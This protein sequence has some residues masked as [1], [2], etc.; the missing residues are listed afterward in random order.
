MRASSRHVRISRRTRSVR[1]ALVALV[2]ALVVGLAGPVAVAVAESRHG[3]DAVV[4]EVRVP[5][6]TTAGSDLRV[7]VRAVDARGRVVRDYRGTVALTSTSASDGLPATYAFTTRDR[8]THTF[9]RVELR[10]AGPGTVTAADVARP[11]VTGTS[12]DVVVRPGRAREL[13]VTTPATTAAGTRADV[14]VTAQDRW[15]N[16][17]SSYTG[18]VALRSTDT[19]DG[20]V[21]EPRRH[22]FTRAD[23]GTVTFTDPVGVVLVTEGVQTVSAA[24]VR[25]RWLAGSATVTVTPV[26]VPTGGL[27]AQG[28]GMDLFGGLGDGGEDEYAT[29]DLR[30]VVGGAVWTDV[31]AGEFSS[32]GVREDGTLWAWGSI[33]RDGEYLDQGEPLR[34]GD[35][36]DWASVAGE[37]ALKRDGTLW[38]WEPTE[39]GGPPLGVPVQVGT[40]A[41]WADVADG[42][43]HVVALKT[44]GTLWSWGDTNHWGQQGNG[45]GEP[46]PA[47]RQVGTDADWASISAHVYQSVAI[48]TDGTLWGWGLDPADA[49]RPDAEP[50]VRTVPEQVGTDSDWAVV[51]AGYLHT[52]ALKRDGTLWSWGDNA[53]GALG[54]GTTTSSAVPVPES[55]GATWTAVAAGDGLTAAVATDGTL[56]RWGNGEL[57]APSPE[58]PFPDPAQVGTDTGW[59]AVT[60]DGQDHVHALRR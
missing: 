7:T 27:E 48:K 54:D 49:A 16:T 36:A 6:R 28:W 51:D 23:A 45:T 19:G 47:P 2:A 22:R 26:P 18:T 1:G 52:A 60:A 25:R 59:A 58:T 37:Q 42:L 40:D 43:G 53:L 50:R 57:G 41:D 12:R 46:G 34:L 38:T 10:T 20:A 15:G 30:T 17:A 4:L 33:G 24:D 14:T 11:A 32:A 9:R 39:A 55:R 44:D 35:D 56:W 29:P 3:P 21:V 13:V 31:S 8:G 5:G